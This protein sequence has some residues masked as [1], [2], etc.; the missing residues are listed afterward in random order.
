MSIS[1]CIFP[2]SHISNKYEGNKLLLY[3]IELGESDPTL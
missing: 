1:D 3:E 2:E